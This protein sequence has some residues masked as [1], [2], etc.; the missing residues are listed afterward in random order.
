MRLI[1]EHAATSSG[2]GTAALRAL[3]RES[4]DVLENTA[5]AKAAAGFEEGS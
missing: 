5:T 1:S 4:A 3:S 2:I